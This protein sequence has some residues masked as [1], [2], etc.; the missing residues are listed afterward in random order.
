LVR[1]DWDHLFRQN[2]WILIPEYEDLEMLRKATVTEAPEDRF[3]MNLDQ[4]FGR[5]VFKYILVPLQK[6]ESPLCRFE[7]LRANGKDSPHNYPYSTLGPLPTHVKPQYVV[8]NSGEKLQTYSYGQLLR[9]VSI[10]EREDILPNILSVIEIHQHWTTMAIPEGLNGP[11]SGNEDGPDAD[12]L[13]P[14]SSVPFNG[15]KGSQM[16][17]EDDIQSTSTSGSTGDTWI[18]EHSGNTSKEVSRMAGISSWAE[19]CTEAASNGGWEEVF[20]DDQ[21]AAYAKEPSSSVPL[22]ETWHGWKPR[23]E[24][25]EGKCTPFNT[26]KFSS[27]DWALYEEHSYLTRA[28]S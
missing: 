20:D 22:P 4:M 9:L 16:Y 27:N 25:C 15:S 5:G 11:R 21:V 12:C 24:R 19:H 13:S 1:V 28:V 8:F 6:L 17:D 3:Q 7:G 14:A 2:K 26:A 18:D 10:L 23:W